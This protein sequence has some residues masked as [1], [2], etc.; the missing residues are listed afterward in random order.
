MSN[1]KNNERV[2]LVKL[3]SDGPKEVKAGD[4]TG[5]LEVRPQGHSLELVI[6]PIFRYPSDLHLGKRI[7]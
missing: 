4:V 2:E 7:K 6:E 3:A 5:I 1:K